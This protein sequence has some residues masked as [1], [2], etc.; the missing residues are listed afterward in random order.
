LFRA[1]AIGQKSRPDFAIRRDSRGHSGLGGA[2]RG[3]FSGI[4]SIGDHLDVDIADP[5]DYFA[6]D[7]NTHAIFLCVE[8]IK[9]ARKFM[10]AG[11]A[12]R[13][14]P[15]VVVKSVRMAQGAKAAA[16]HTS[17][18]AGSDAVY[19]AAVQRAGMLRVSD[20]R[21]FFDCAES[22]RRVNSLPGKRLSILTN[23]G[24]IGVLA[25]DRVAELGA[26]SPLKSRLPS[27]RSWMRCCLRRGPDQTRSTSSATPILRAMQ[28]RMECC[29]AT[30]R[31]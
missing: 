19:D 17:A 18:S 5:L 11:H 12:A 24:G 30:P 7:N 1:H 21:E 8:A 25:I 28:R 4:V 6:L 31:Q 13:I 16:T 20:L 26:A 9:D 15:V 22:L 29:S 2:A 3:R 27:V 14:E 10:S 23:G